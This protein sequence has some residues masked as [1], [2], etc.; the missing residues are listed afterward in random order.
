MSSPNLPFAGRVP[1]LQ[2]EIFK[3]LPAHTQ[4]PPQDQEYYVRQV[5]NDFLPQ[6]QPKEAPRHCSCAEY[7][8]S[9]SFVSNARTST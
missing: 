8:L 5:W 1:S 9:P 2:G 4:S 3:P 7:A 6:L